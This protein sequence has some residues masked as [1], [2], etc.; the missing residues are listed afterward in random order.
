VNPNVALFL[1]FLCHEDEQTAIERGI[2]GA[3]FFGFSLAYYYVF[4]KHQP[5]ISSIWDYFC[6]HRRDL[7]FA[8]ELIH[9]DSK[10][11]GIKLLEQGLGSFRG[12]VGTPEQLIDL[13]GRYE[14]AGVDQVVFAAQ[15]GPNKHEH[16]CESLDTFAKKVMPHFAERDAAHQAE[17]RARLA[18]AL[19]RAIARR[20]KQT[21]VARGEYIVTPQGEPGPVGALRVFPGTDGRAQAG[22]ANG[23]SARAGM[24]VLGWLVKGRSDAQIEKLMPLLGPM[25]FRGMERAFRP[26]RA[27]G[28]SGEIE[29]DLQKNGSVKKW[30]V[31]VADGKATVRE[32]AAK[33]PRLLMRMSAPTFARL[34]AGELQPVTAVLEGKLEAEGE[35]RLMNRI[36]EMFGGPSNY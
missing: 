8:R 32:G 13:L 12:A 14:K 27:L 30:A 24:A 19:E 15:A 33:K 25:I 34:S 9:P 35:L 22:A 18:P 23:W 6:D 17:K 4:G 21:R 3:H 11:L 28:F 29:Y 1:P 7:G 20:P 26:D 2:D 31:R 5:G 16:I 36:G 10:P